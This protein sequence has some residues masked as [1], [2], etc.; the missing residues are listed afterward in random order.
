M[1]LFRFRQKAHI[2]R[3]FINYLDHGINPFVKGF[4]LIFFINLCVAVPERKH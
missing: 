4:I 3:G 1:Y 2:L